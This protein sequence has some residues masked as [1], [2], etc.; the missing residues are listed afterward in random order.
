[1]LGFPRIVHH[2]E[3]NVL[4]ACNTNLEVVELVGLECHGD[5]DELIASY[6]I[7]RSSRH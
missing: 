6:H 5:N 1:M 3:A 4:R 2:A 7:K